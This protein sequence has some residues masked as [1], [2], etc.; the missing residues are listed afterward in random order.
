MAERNGRALPSTELPAALRDLGRSIAYPATPPLA[1]SVGRTLREERVRGRPIVP[2]LVLWS[3]RRIVVAIVIALMLLGG[4]AVATKLAIGAITVRVVPSPSLPRPT[5]PDASPSFGEA[6]TPAAAADAAG[7]RLLAPADIAR[8]E[9][10]YTVETVA[11]TQVV[12]LTWAPSAELPEV[13]GTGAGLVLMELP[14][15]IELAYKELVADVGAIEPARVNGRQAFWVTGPHDLV[16]H[17]AQGEQRFY[18]TGNVLVWRSGD[19]TLRMETSI[20][21]HSAVALA[22]TVR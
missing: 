14:G 13:G 21:R 18:V 11:G 9:A 4:A 2:P 5:L 6:L 17:T 22:E 3:R 8:P 20:D 16:V 7:F 12:I 1:T 10:A 15:E 19:V